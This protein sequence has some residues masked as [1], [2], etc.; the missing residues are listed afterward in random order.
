MSTTTWKWKEKF[1][2]AWKDFKEFF[3]DDLP[4]KFEDWWDDAKEKFNRI[5]SDM[6][7]MKEEYTAKAK[8]KAT[9]AELEAHKQAEEIEEDYQARFDEVDTTFGKYGNH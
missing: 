7:H 1:N 3:T 6:W 9:E 8:L 4:E 5:K 2:N